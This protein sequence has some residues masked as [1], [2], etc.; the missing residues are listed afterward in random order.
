M[1]R[2]RVFDRQRVLEKAMLVFWQKGVDDA[3]I[4][5][6]LK[7]MKI[8]RSSLY[9]TFGNKDNLL[10]ESIRC[11]MDARKTEREVLDD[12]QD[13]RLSIMR[14]FQEHI[15]RVFDENEPDGCLITSTAASIDHQS[16]LIQQAVETSFKDIESS[17]MNLL[18]TGKT[19]GQIDSKIDSKKWAFLLLNLHHSI[20]I[21]SKINHNKED[22]I[23]MIELVLSLL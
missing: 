23:R 8:S 19:N 9:E 3:S 21:T 22:F 20:N 1:T 4:A 12:S 15:A 7:E 17:L 13:V 14:Y 5:D 6:L 10:L 18:E 11:Y 2:T 16:A